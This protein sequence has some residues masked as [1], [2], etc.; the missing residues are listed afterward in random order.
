MTH[1]CGA[2]T[3][4]GKKCRNTV[5]RQGFCWIHKQSKGKN[6]N[7]KNDN[8]YAKEEDCKDLCPKT[9]YSSFI[10]TNCISDCKWEALTCAGWKNSR[11]SALFQMIPISVEKI[12][13]KGQDGNET[14]TLKLNLDFKNKSLHCTGKLYYGYGNDAHIPTSNDYREARKKVF[15]TK[16]LP[17]NLNPENTIV[18]TTVLSEKRIEH[19]ASYFM[20]P[21]KFNR[22]TRVLTYEMTKYDANLPLNSLNSGENG[23]FNVPLTMALQFGTIKV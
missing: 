18:D 20:Y 8:N 4:K 12:K 21:T 9:W 2:L 6:G 11:D 17:A 22:E 23:Q 1:L 3:S 19:K 16:L 14:E 5:T 10:N 15:F 7:G 13:V